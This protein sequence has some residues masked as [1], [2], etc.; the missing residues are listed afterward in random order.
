[1]ASGIAKLLKILEN[2]Y[3]GSNCDSMRPT[4]DF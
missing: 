1:M 2:D 3:E 4:N